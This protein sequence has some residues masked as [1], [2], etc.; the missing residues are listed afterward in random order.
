MEIGALA[1]KWGGR[2]TPFLAK[3]WLKPPLMA[4]MGWPKPPSSLWGWS[5]HPKRPKKKIIIKN[6][7]RKKKERKN[8]F[9]FW[10]W[11]QLPPKAQ[12]H[13]FFFFGLSRWPNHPQGLGGGRNHPIQPVW[14]GF[15]PR[16][17]PATHSFLGWPRA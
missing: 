10:G 13:S 5:G 1:Q 4:N 16:G 17:C 14:G 12:T 7:K 8:G 6:K 9:G 3:G 2:T 11:L 15:G